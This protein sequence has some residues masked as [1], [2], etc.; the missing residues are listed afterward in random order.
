MHF[1]VRIGVF[2][3]RYRKL[4]GTYNNFFIFVHS[5]M[6]RWA[7]ATS[8]VEV[9]LQLLLKIIDDNSWLARVLILNF[10]WNVFHVVLFNNKLLLFMLNKED[11]FGFI[12]SLRIQVTL[13]MSICF[14]LNRKFSSF[15]KLY[16]ATLSPVELVVYDCHSGV[17]KLLSTPQFLIS[18]IMAKFPYAC[19]FDTYARI[20][21]VYD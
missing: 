9:W 16:R 19:L 20:W 1:K 4:S 14:L 10:K 21:I 12:H 15:N 8:S 3:R 18:L 13:W 11:A 5:I 7:S 17:R 6:A 2:S